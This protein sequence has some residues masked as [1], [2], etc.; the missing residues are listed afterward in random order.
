MDITSDSADKGQ[1]E[2]EEALRKITGDSFRG[3]ISAADA[4]ELLKKTGLSV[5]EL[6]LWLASFAANYALP[7]ISDYKVG[8]VVEG[9][10]AQ[11]APIGALYYGANMEFA[12]EALSFTLHAEQAAIVNA[13][14][15][16][17][18]GLT[19]I[20]IDEA[21]C[22]YCRQFLYETSTAQNKQGAGVVV[23]L[24]GREP[25]NLTA[26]LPQAFG[27]SDL[28]VNDAL[29]N[30]ESH[31]LVLDNPPKDDPVVLAALDAAN[32]S[33]APYTQGYAGVA[34]QTQSGAI[35]T[36]RYGENAA[37]NPSISPLESALV[38]WDLAGTPS[39]LLTRCVLVERLS[40]SNQ[41]RATTAVLKAF[42][43]RV[44]ELWPAHEPQ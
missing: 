2:R 40:T 36:G 34:I 18:T 35:F 43:N 15:N 19:S 37:F 11:S 21:P 3:V 13:W 44:P 20:A 12:G 17:E 10:R 16:G 7:V 32:A 27:P 6:V 28:G 24:E 33:Y 1:R 5:Q 41:L 39:D 25:Q 14:Q 31:S 8:A 42:A 4:A 38:M 26:L 9:V 22:G 29:M 30:P 23:Y